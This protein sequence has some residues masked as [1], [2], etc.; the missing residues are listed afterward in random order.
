MVFTSLT[1]AL[2]WSALDAIPVIPPEISPVARPAHSELC[3]VIT[4]PALNNLKFPL[5]N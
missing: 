2:I 3:R 1:A 5:N 4:L